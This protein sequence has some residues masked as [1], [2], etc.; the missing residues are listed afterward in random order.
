MTTSV[1][2]NATFLVQSQ[3]PDHLLAQPWKRAQ[4]YNE[5]GN[6]TGT[7]EIFVAPSLRHRATPI[8][9]R[10]VLSI[11]CRQRITESKYTAESKHRGPGTSLRSRA[12]AMVYV[13]HSPKVLMGKIP[14]PKMRMNFITEGDGAEPGD[15]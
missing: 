14:H 2:Q 4:H 13:C 1:T 12:S 11:C 5:A 15:T 9:F 8:R 10:K 7:W 3:I 6:T